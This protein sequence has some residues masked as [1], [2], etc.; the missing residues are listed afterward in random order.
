VCLSYP[1]ILVTLVLHFVRVSLLLLLCFFFF[2]SSFHPTPPLV[3]SAQTAGK[4]HPYLF[5]QCQAVHARSLLPCQDSPG[6]RFTYTAAVTCPIALTAVMS[7]LGNG[8]SVDAAAGTRTFLFNQ[9]VPIPSYLVALAVGE[10]AS[11]DIGPRSTAWSE[12]SMID[13]VAAEVGSC[14]VWVLL[15]FPVCRAKFVLVEC[16]F[17][18]RSPSLRLERSC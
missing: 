12:P 9:P 13:A 3:S 11:K 17:L 16:S 10:L 8:S 7:A 15:R 5:T 6:V 14:V 18:R 4:V 1:R 2:S